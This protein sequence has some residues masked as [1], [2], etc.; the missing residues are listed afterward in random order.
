MS[1]EKDL[2]GLPEEIQ[3][4]IKEA[5]EADT[6]E[7][8]EDTPIVFLPEGT[9]KL[10][11][12]LD[13]QGKFCREMYRYK[14]NGIETPNGKKSIYLPYVEDNPIEKLQKELES[15]GYGNAWMY[16]PSQH[17]LCYA[18]LIS[19]DEKNDA[20]KLNQLVILEM[21]WKV[22][23]QIMSCIR[24]FNPQVVYDMFNPE[25]EMNVW[26]INYKRGRGGNVSV[27]GDMHI[28]CSIDPLPEGT[29]PLTQC[30]VAEGEQQDSESVALVVSH[31]RKLIKQI[32][33]SKEPDQENAART[34]PESPP[35][36]KEEHTPKESIEPPKES[37]E[38][39]CP[40][41]AK[42]FKWSDPQMDPECVLCALAKE[43]KEAK[44]AK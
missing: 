40:S 20:V 19:S 12:Y 13:P 42:G 18:W 39:S 7:S 43:C 34:S 31:M 38:G 1:E 26:S 29:L 32:G 25:K 24:E 35:F 4:L 16:A 28:K 22:W 30:W 10:R 8:G 5:E 36:D 27:A 6:G 11:F 15:L 41:E 3:K 37:T 14:L 44:A 21:K 2:S 33:S 9:T 23:N 17:F